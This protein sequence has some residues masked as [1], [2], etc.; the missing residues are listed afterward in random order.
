MPPAG[1]CRSASPASSGSVARA[2]PAATAAIRSLT[3]E[4]FLPDPEHPGARRYRS[5]DRVRW[6]ADGTL[7]F[8]GRI[9]RQ[10]KVRGVRVEPARGG[11]G[12]ARA[13]RC[14]RRRRGTIRT[15]PRRS[16]PRCLRGIPTPGS[17]LP[18]AALREHAL[19]ALPA[20]MVPTAWVGLEALP[21]NA[22]GKVDRDRLPTPGR[23]HLARESS[24]AA[25]PR[26]E[27]ERRVVAAFETVLGRRSGR[28]RGG[29]LR[30]RRTLA[31]GGGAVHRAGARGRRRLP[32]ASVL[33]A[34]TPRALAARTARRTRRGGGGRCWCS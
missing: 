28:R 34:P 17:P 7:E 19:A 31:V 9:D 5:G 21:L 16:R 15:R 6:R 18:A 3:A 4:R 10:I 25:A 33:E 23:E 12:A 30:A 8:L 2:S 22:S 24:V 11:A 27:T 14:P 26:S 20:A 13:R 32:L 29:L 1:R